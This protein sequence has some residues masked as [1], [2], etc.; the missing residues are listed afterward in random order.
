MDVPSANDIEHCYDWKNDAICDDVCNVPEFQFD[1]G[2]CCLDLVAS[3]WC[4][5]CFCY[6]DCSVHDPHD[7]ALA[8]STDLPNLTTTTMSNVVDGDIFYFKD[9]DTLI[10]IF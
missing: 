7:L 2:D 8:T 4:W 3:A 9:L 5:H 1:G 6:D 10:C